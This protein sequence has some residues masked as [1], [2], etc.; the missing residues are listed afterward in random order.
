MVMP[1]CSISSIN[2][3]SMSHP[4]DL[5]HFRIAKKFIHDSVIADADAVGTFGTTELF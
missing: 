2:I 4:L 5:H 3:L 1:F